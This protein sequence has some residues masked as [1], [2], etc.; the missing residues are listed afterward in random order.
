M[1]S[2]ENEK[3]LLDEVIAQA[4]VLAIEIEKGGDHTDTLQNSPGAP[5]GGGAQAAG[6]LP[7]RGKLQPLAAERYMMASSNEEKNTY[8]HLEARLAQ[9]KKI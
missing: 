6:A 1:L 9:M 5:I 7:G 4:L 3:D 2:N 8:A